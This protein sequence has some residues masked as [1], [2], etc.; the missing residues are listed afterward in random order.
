MAQDRVR[1]GASYFLQF[2]PCRTEK[3]VQSRIYNR[4]NSNNIGA[5]RVLYALA[6]ASDDTIAK[7]ASGEIPATAEAIQ[8]RKR[9]EKAEEKARKEEQARLEAEKKAETFEQQ[10]IWS[11]AE[12][13]LVKSE[14]EGLKQELEARSTPEIQHIEVPTDPADVKERMEKL[15][16]WHKKAMGE[17]DK[18]GE[19]LKAQQEANKKLFED[20]ARIRKE[21]SSTWISRYNDEERQERL[22]V[23]EVKR[24]V[25]SAVSEVGG[26]VRRTLSEL[27]SAID[28]RH[29]DSDEWEMIELATNQL[30]SAVEQF[31]QL[32]PGFVSSVIDSEM[33]QHARVVPVDAIKIEDEMNAIPGGYDLDTVETE[34]TAH[35]SRQ[36]DSTSFVPPI[37]FEDAMNSWFIHLERI[38]SVKTCNGDIFRSAVRNLCGGGIRSVFDDDKRALEMMEKVYVEQP[39]KWYLIGSLIVHGKPLPLYKTREE[40]EKV[41]GIEE[42]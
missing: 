2:H 15:K 24:R 32:K 5:G 40:A 37:L 6:E 10:Y 30:R 8:E 14:N 39:H 42:E 1:Y 23:M 31:E 27:P 17:R 11:Q 19:Q 12:S 38:Y 26:F 18:K 4:C 35:D 28:C 21:L 9:A 36:F 41:L 13:E 7:V 3:P 16:D 25:R 33:L 22:Y 34:I 29:L 20:N